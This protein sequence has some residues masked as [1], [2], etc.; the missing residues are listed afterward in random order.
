MHYGGNNTMPRTKQTLSKKNCPVC[1]RLFRPKTKW[2]KYDKPRC[3]KAAFDQRI[4]AKLRRL[5]ELESQG[6]A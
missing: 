1:N 3:A 5:E 4:A 6:A 2:Q